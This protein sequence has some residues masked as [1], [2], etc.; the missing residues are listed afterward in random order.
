MLVCLIGKYLCKLQ[1]HLGYCA[2]PISYYFMSNNYIVVKNKSLLSSCK[3]NLQPVNAISHSKK[4]I[5]V[6]LNI[7][8]CATQQMS[9]KSMREKLNNYGEDAVS[10]PL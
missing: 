3:K 2:S 10:Q 9:I 8:F 4:I 6:L 7:T 1:D 5:S